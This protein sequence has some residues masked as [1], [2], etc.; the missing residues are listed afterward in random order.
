MTVSEHVFQCAGFW[1]ALVSAAKLV[2]F[3]N[4][5]FR[6]RGLAFKRYYR[7]LSETLTLLVGT[8]AS[9]ADYKKGLPAARSGDYA[10]ALREWTPQALYFLRKNELV[11]MV[12][13]DKPTSSRNGASQW[14]D[15]RNIFG[16]N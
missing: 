16:K 8:P 12:A 2:C 5:S 7:S 4:K 6:S 9:S 1:P 14:R 13:K 11:E 10:T 3:T 15:D